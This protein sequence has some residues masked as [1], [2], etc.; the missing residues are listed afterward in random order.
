MPKTVPALRAAPPSTCLAPR[1]AEPLRAALALAVA[2]GLGGAARAQDP[3]QEPATEPVAMEE[4]PAPIVLG[5]DDRP[6]EFAYQ[7]Y[8]AIQH[9]L[10]FEFAVLPPLVLPTVGSPEL[11]NVG[12]DPKTLPIAPISVRTQDAA[13][14]IRTVHVSLSESPSTLLSLDNRQSL[15]WRIDGLP[16]AAEAPANAVVPVRPTAVDP[17][18]FKLGAT[19]GAQD[20]IRAPLLDAIAWQAQADVGAGAAPARGSTVVRRSLRLTAGWDRASDVAF[21]LSQ[22]V[23][24]G[25]G[26]AYQHYATGVRASL[27]DPPEATRFSGFVE[28]SGEHLALNNLADNLGAT[29]NAGATWRANPTTQ[30]DFSLS[31]GLA[32]TADTQSNVGLQVKF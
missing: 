29:V 15:Q 16:G 30:V 3:S 14:V 21:N 25:G 7:T 5:E 19:W 8:D 22:G 4:A 23:Q 6:D 12:R 28:L 11:R 13:D 32:P 10:D 24:V 20:R 2:L 9:T 17:Q 26:G 1:L 18:G 31:R 27:F